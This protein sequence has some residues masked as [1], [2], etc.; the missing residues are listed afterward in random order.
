MAIRGYGAVV[1]YPDASDSESELVAG[2]VQ[3]A[4]FLAVNLV[5]K[6]GSLKQDNW[7]K[8]DIWTK[9]QSKFTTCKDLRI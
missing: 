1:T 7:T 9:T 4:L 5:L 6:T 3:T 8:Q 2:G